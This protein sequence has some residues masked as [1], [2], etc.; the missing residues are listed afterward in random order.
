MMIRL[1]MQL[2]V[3]LFAPTALADWAYENYKDVQNNGNYL[4]DSDEKTLFELQKSEKSGVD[5][6]GLNGM[7]SAAGEVTF[8][9]GSSRPVIVCAVLE[10]C[11]IA[12]EEGEIIS[13]VQIGDS[14]RW[15]VSSALSGVNEDSIQHLIIKPL[16]N[17]LKTSMVVATNKR[18]YHLRLKS[19]FDDFMPL[20][21]FIYPDQD[22][23][24]INNNFI[25]HQKDKLTS[26][27][28]NNSGEGVDANKLK[29]DYEFEGDDEIM[30]IRVYHDG[31]KTYIDM[32]ENLYARKTP[33]LLIVSKKGGWFSSDREHV[34][35]YRIQ[36]NRYII[37]GV[38]QEAKLIL[39][40]DGENYSVEIRLKDI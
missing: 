17:G 13:S 2:F 34:A 39:G 21:K 30:P 15:K 27:I 3:L 25:K 38:L 10:L 8:A 36:N 7:V 28:K 11:D 19:T 29:F 31:K 22:L 33:A 14:A 23:D 6:M 32:K 12:F 40:E 4:T 1:L 9:Y 18:T 16:D 35:N 5:G 20:V 37:D 26:S 24:N